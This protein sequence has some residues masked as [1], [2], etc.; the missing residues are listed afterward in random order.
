M[1]F[2]QFSLQFFDRAITISICTGSSNFQRHDGIKSL[3]PSQRDSAHQ[4]V[5]IDQVDRAHPAPG[6]KTG[7]LLI[8]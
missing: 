2:G 3:V 7:N 5:R 6:A 1:S 4:R 8:G